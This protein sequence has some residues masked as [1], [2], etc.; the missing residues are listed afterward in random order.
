MPGLTI[1]LLGAARI[2]ADEHTLDLRVRKE[3]ALLAYLAV[4]Q[5]RHRRESLLGLLWPDS[6]EDIARNNLRVVLAGLR[7]ALGPA[8]QA[9]LIADRQYVQLAPGHTLDVAAFRGALAA[10]AR[11]AHPALERCDTCAE[12]LAEAVALYRDEF[13]T[14]FSLPDST[15]FE[16]W[17]VIQREQLQQQ[18]L[19][20][21]DALTTI[22]EQRADHAAQCRYARRQLALEP[23]RESAYA[24]LMR[25]LW[26]LGQRGAALEQ[27]EA[28]R[29]VLET[30]LGLEPSP[31]L[32][33]LYQHM[34]SGTL[35]QPAPRPAAPPSSASPEPAAAE[36]H[37][38]YPPL[39]GRERE[40]ADVCALLR[41][42]DAR[43]VTLTGTGGVGKSAIALRVAA[44]L[45]Q[46]E[47]EQ[48]V[49]LV[50]L[51]A[52]D[53]ADL[54]LAQIARALD[55][56]E[57]ADQPLPE[58]IRDHLRGRRVLL[59]LDNF[60]PLLSAAPLLAELLAQCRELKLLVSSRAALRLG[61][62]QVVQVNPL[63]L[64]PLAPLPALEQLATFPAVALF[65]E[66]ARA[67][68]PGFQL[69]AA[70]ARAVAEICARLDGLPLAL[71]L[72]AA[73][74]RLLTP[75]DLLARLHEPLQIL[76]SEARDAP[77]RQRTLRNTI[78]WSE[79]LLGAAQQ[80]AFARMS[81]FA[82]GCTA[83][84][85][86][87]VLQDE[88]EVGGTPEHSANLDILDALAELIDSNLLRQELGPGG[89]PRF[90]MLETI[91][92]FAQERLAARG[93]LAHLR[94]AHA[95]YFLALAERAEPQLQGAEQ[96]L[97]LDRLE[98]EHD[99][100][101][102]ALA[103]CLEDGAAERQTAHLESGLRL[104][105]ALGEF[106]W[107]RGHLTEGR[108]WLGRL[109]SARSAPAGKE[110]SAAV[111]AKAL[112]RA[113][114]LAYG[115]GDYR[116]ACA[117]L[118]DSLALFR[119]QGDTRGVACVLRGLGNPFAAL[120]DEP[121][122]ASLRAESLALFRQISDWWGIA[123]MLLEIGRDERDPA[124]QRALLEESL[125][126][127]RAGGY[128]RT[129]ASALF[130]LSSLV[131]DAGETL[132]ARELLHEALEIGR[133][134]RDSWLVAISG[135]QLGQLLFVQG[136][137]AQARE[138][139]EESLALS[140]EGGHDI[141]IALALDVLGDLA[142]QSGDFAIARERFAEAL[143]FFQQFSDTARSNWS[144]QKLQQAERAI[145]PPAA[146]PGPPE[147]AP[148]H[149]ATPG[150][151]RAFQTNVPAQATSFVGREAQLADL[152]ATLA[153]ARLITLTGP[154]G[155]GKTR[156]ALELAAASGSRYADGAWLVALEPLQDPAL[157][158]Q[159][160]A[161]ALGVKTVSAQSVG[162]LLS[163]ALRPKQLLLILDNCEHL[164]MACQALAAQ[165]LRDCPRITILATSREMLHAADEVVWPV[166]PLSAPESASAE[167]EYLLRYEGI[168]L[169]VE[170]ARAASAGFAL[171]A[172]NAPAV[173]QICRQLDSMP[174]AIE[175]AAARARHMPVETIAARLN[176][177]FSLL[178]GGSYPTPRQQHLRTAID[179]SHALL[180][181]DEQSCF[182]R[183]AVFAGGFTLEAAEGIAGT[184]GNLDTV[185][186]LAQLIDKSL[187]V[188]EQ[189]PEGLRYRLLETMRAYAREQLLQSGDAETIHNR[190]A[191][192][193]LRLAEQAETQFVGDS[194]I[195]WLDQIA[196]EHANMRAAVDWA[197]EHGGTLAALRLVTA[198][199]YFWRVRGFY[200]EGIDLLGELLAHPGT[201]GNTTVRARALNA[202]GYLE[203]VRGQQ[204]RARELLETALA[205]GRAQADLPISAFALRYLSALANAQGQL[206]QARACGE[207][208]LAI[209]RA[210]GASNDIAGTAMYLGD[211]VLAQGDDDRA[212]AL[213]AE[214]VALLRTHRNSIALPYPLRHLGYLALR[215]GQ[216]ARA[217][218]LC[219]ESLRLNLAVSDQQGVAACLV[220]LAAA[221]AASGHVEQAGRMLGHAEAVLGTLQSQLLPFDRAQHDQLR[222]M[223]AERLGSSA[224]L[225]AA[226]AGQAMAIDQLLGEAA[227]ATESVAAPPS[228]LPAWLQPCIG[229]DV[230]IR[231][232]TALLRQPDVRIL[233]LVGVGGMGKTRLAQ[234]LGQH[235]L[236][237]FA[238]GVR[239]VA[240]APLTRPAE[241]APTIL[242]ALDA[243]PNNDDPR[244]ALLHSLQA[245]RLLLILDNFEH[246]IDGAD[247][248]AEI[249][250]AAPRVTILA[251]SRERLHLQSEHPYVLGGLAFTSRATL[252]E[253]AES[254]AVRLFVQ[255]AQRARANFKLNAGNLGAVLRICRLVEGMPL[256]LELAATWVEMLTPDDIASEIEQSADFLA[257]EWRDFPERQRSMRAVFDWS[258]RLLSDA[259]RQGFQQLSVFRGGFSRQAAQ[260]VAGASLGVLNRLI[261][262]ALVRF[263]QSNEGAGRYELHELLRQFAAEQLARSA[264]ER[265]AVEARHGAF[266]LD[267]IAKREQRLVRNEPREAA[268]EIRGE[269]DNARQAWAWASTN[270]QVELLDS[271]AYSLFQ[272]YFYTGQFSE[273]EH[274]FAHA[275]EHV[276]LHA[277]RLP[278]G[279][280]GTRRAWAVLSKLLAL[281]ARA[282]AGYGKNGLAL[283]LALQAVAV[284]EANGGV[285]GA[286]LGHLTAGRTLGRMG[287][288]EGYRT[289]LE[290]AR[291]LVRRHQNEHQP[292]DGLLEVEYS[293]CV[294]LGSFTLI[295]ENHYPAARQFFL[296]ALHIAQT[297]GSLHREMTAV[298]NLGN[299]NRLSG[300][301]AA[302]RTAY[303]R[304]LQ[305]ART[306]GS[307][308]GEGTVLAELGEVVRLQGDY[309]RAQG[310]LEQALPILHDIDEYAEAAFALS[311]L[312]RIHLFQGSFGRAR[313]VLEQFEQTI[314][315]IDSHEEEVHG[316]LSWA[317]LAHQT[318]R[319][320]QAL[321]HAEKAR[322]LAVTSGSREGQAGALIL[323]GH[324]HARLGGLGQAEAAYQ[325][326]Q[327]LYDELGKAPFAAEARAGLAHVTLARGE[328][329]GA[330]GYAEAIVQAL[331]E[332][333]RA[334]MDEPFFI[335]L[336]CFLVLEA[337]SDPRAAGV[338]RAAY[339]LLLEYASHISDAAPRRSFLESVA[340]HYEILQ[341]SKA[342]QAIVAAD[343]RDTPGWRAE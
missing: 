3:L 192:F 107:P 97:W 230:E 302:A 329:A 176:D 77:A 177:R 57:A 288:N 332:H 63:A 299:C 184:P 279:E 196:A 282:L 21:L 256:G 136:Y 219:E 90:C 73:R 127:A 317:W 278:A 86:A 248:V 218:A 74:V 221:S 135:V 301:Y 272:F 321:E 251:T 115:Q 102:A 182:R 280:P 33:D 234:E 165:L 19:D 148:D 85:A 191:A 91:R 18:A 331:D 188:A 69:S 268:A 156:L 48:R 123:W 93:E 258:W 261:H 114:E 59:V 67:A 340:T 66:R 227:P 151:D 308:W 120:S 175:L 226:S 336:S 160:V 328:L 68:L 23:W 106:W 88:R 25:G 10:V 315:A 81:V 276:T 119:Q 283:P 38:A 43:L 225:A 284:G 168:S 339:D 254:A 50:A 313:D 193:F 223:L 166:P 84:A 187:L 116:E 316:Q 295:I 335:Y 155:C 36:P 121:Q 220:G 228:N 270:A 185:E 181:E 34:L 79:Q 277:S 113:G 245:K 137:I 15:L 94:A 89:V 286:A 233:T 5:Q 100:L 265:A 144:L 292:L 239:F 125:A 83:E 264:T 325:Q 138:L 180:G 78:A 6:P 171:T 250:E 142:L 109:L 101:R 194:Q 241:L 281:Q 202:A 56:H 229:R 41:R 249:I 96:T 303:E 159:A 197:T 7:R 111:V 103:W 31:A 162:D 12:R 75:G 297:Q 213:Y 163:A 300:D 324:A 327:A 147:P 108:R 310:L 214:S 204:A 263:D 275:A 53:N 314:G 267:F 189:R 9:A 173:V 342:Q 8:G 338:L 65:V 117:L 243:P 291:Q 150:E 262:K 183:L 122:A 287:R 32:A 240:L 341:A 247:L 304:A 199:R 124:R 45:R 154:S 112:Y 26:A 271:S 104:A 237:H 172:R 334:G 139:L 242:A 210:L 190:H 99:N 343:T 333:P 141:C 27:Y 203:F 259:E 260:A 161:E 318:G 253:A 170:R 257:T 132:Q 289:H 306:I 98:G 13:L 200:A 319:H 205:I 51:D 44:E 4:E 143:G 76:R 14:G 255:G 134:L 118:Q 82:G 153:R 149:D 158:P 236:K 92:A 186:L 28:C 201:A 311:S 209:Y 129:I 146:P 293:A 309:G 238:D 87:A 266:Y 178:K 231:E 294:W 198:L 320:D 110:I 152:R 64:P 133:D 298:A 37:R 232:L 11:H 126:L 235:S 215:R 296:E 212:E 322:R 224:L 169:F 208:S 330:L 312:A 35:A 22:C 39:I 285:E 206:D 55:V 30:E 307:R 290:L 252:A 16:E 2:T 20:A 195:A 273:G 40:I 58:R 274:A 71:E 29:R 80:A 95:R 105:A 244:Q 54:A 61:V 179:W 49:V 47:P 305:I 42:P 167:P 216:P 1:E 246:L 24:Q 52:G 60:E 130:N 217:A 164:L 140:R 211:I 128:K 222:A 337:S 207:E 72:A 62:E 157:V 269:I 131:R 326:A 323:L 174:L 70:N 17:A 145:L 46:A